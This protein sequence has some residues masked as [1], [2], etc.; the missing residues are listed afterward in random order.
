MPG[1]LVIKVVVTSLLYHGLS[2]PGRFAVLR[3]HCALPDD[4]DLPR[5]GLPASCPDCPV[6][7]CLELGVQ[8]PSSSVC[9]WGVFMIANGLQT[10]S[11]DKP[12]GTR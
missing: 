4:L 2:G 11:Q 12:L 1:E 6:P 9:V 8:G 5:W 3:D 10:P 7:F